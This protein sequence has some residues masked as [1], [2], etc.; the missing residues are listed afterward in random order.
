MISQIKQSHTIKEAMIFAAGKGNRMRYKTK[1]IAKPLIKIK[2]NEL[3]NVNLKKLSAN[4]IKN[5]VVNTSYKHLSVKNFINCFKLRNK[6]PKIKI[7]YE[8]ERLETGGGVKKAFNYF[9]TDNILL[10]N[11]DSLLVNSLRECPIKKLSKNFLPNKMDILL[12]LS[13]I[14]D[15]VGYDGAG[16]YVKNCQAKLSLINRK[17]NYYFRKNALVFTGW[18]VINKNILCNIHSK[19]FSLNKL[20]DFAEKNK[21]LY[22]ITHKGSFLHLSTP[23]SCIQVESYLKHKS[24]SLL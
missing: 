23:K 7:S 24:I 22:G 11:G 21:R 8:N 6:Y 5:C 4:G 10:I 17:K 18:Q 13:S 16:D 1:Y 2:N 20:Y 15:S 19:K 3:L 12:L 14:H 9:N